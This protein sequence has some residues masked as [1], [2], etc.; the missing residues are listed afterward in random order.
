M[1]VVNEDGAVDRE[2]ASHSAFARSRY[3][4]EYETG[5]IWQE[6]ILTKLHQYCDEAYDDE[7]ENIPVMCLHSPPGVVILWVLDIGIGFVVD[8]GLSVCCSCSCSL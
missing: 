8:L 7:E 6:A 4:D 5:E 3:Q 2:D 1:V